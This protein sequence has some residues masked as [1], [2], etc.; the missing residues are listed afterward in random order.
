MVHGD[1]AHEAGEHAQDKPDVH[2][3]FARREAQATEGIGDHQHHG[4]GKNAGEDGNNQGVQIPPG[5]TELRGFGKQTRKIVPSVAL[6]H[7]V[8][9]ICPRFL[10]EGGQH[11]PHYGK[12]PHGC[13]H[14][15]NDILDRFAHGAKRQEQ[16]DDR[17]DKVQPKPRAQIAHKKRLCQQPRSVCRSLEGQESVHA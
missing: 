1:H 13:H 7:D 9:G 10:P 11:Q 5:E 17:Q 14:G 2:Q 3:L 15:K 16:A 8:G 4:G 6:W 12:Q